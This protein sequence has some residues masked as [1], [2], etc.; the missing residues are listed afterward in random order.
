MNSKY[1]Q[2]PL[3]ASSPSNQELNQ[4][5]V[6]EGLKVIGDAATRQNRKLNIASYAAKP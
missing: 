2:G 3:Q 4:L 6:A 1:K 5:A